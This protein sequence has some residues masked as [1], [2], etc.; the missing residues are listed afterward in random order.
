MRHTF[1]RQHSPSIFFIPKIIVA[2]IYLYLKT[3]KLLTDPVVTPIDS[4]AFRFERPVYLLYQ[5]VAIA[6]SGV[7]KISHF[8]II[9]KI[10]VK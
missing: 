2:E 5:Q 6:Y 10:M 1:C 3:V 8:A 4:I 7:K 9:F